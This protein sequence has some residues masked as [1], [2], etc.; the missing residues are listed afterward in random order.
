MPAGATYEPIATQTL[1]SDQANV[2]FSSIS[3]SYTDLILVGN[4]KIA[5]TTSA[6]VFQ[7]NGDTATNYSYTVLTGN[8]TSASSARSSSIGYGIVDFNAYPPTA[9]NTFNNVILHF[10]SYAGSTNK[11]VLGLASSAASGVDRTVSLWRSTAA[12]N[13]IKIY[14]SGAANLSSGSTFTLYGIAR[15]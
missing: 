14:S 12:I 4:I 3:A 5:S 2:T 13:S 15:A 10:F 11:T 6:T 9:S 8:G 7:L 1:A